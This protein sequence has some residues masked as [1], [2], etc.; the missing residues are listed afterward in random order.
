ML[1]SLCS[2]APPGF[3]ENLLYSSGGEMLAENT[4]EFSQSY[5][6]SSARI[7][8]KLPVEV[9]LSVLPPPP[10]DLAIVCGFSAFWADQDLPTF[11]TPWHAQ[12]L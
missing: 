9:D 12:P 11:R 5:R 1:D 6:T 7:M 4:F 2:R 8:E 10:G 3:G